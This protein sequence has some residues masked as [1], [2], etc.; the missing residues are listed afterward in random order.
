MK[1]INREAAKERREGV[2]R[3]R[4]EESEPG[5][6]LTERDCLVAGRSGGGKR[7]L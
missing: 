5:L 7:L 6:L 4:H 2:E 1:L 3:Q